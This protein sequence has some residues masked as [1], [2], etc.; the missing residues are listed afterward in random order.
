MDPT[1]QSNGPVTRRQFLRNG[2]R[3]LTMTGLGVAAGALATR[4][5]A[6]GVGVAD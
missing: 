6:R 5:T 2:A 4:S 3:L 1:P